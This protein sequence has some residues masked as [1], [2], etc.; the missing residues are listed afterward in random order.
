MSLTIARLTHFPLF[1]FRVMR[2]GSLHINSIN[3]ILQCRPSFRNL[4]AA[5]ISEKV[6]E[7]DD[8]DDD[9]DDDQDNDDKNLHQV[10]LKRKESEK[11]AAIRLLL[12]CSSTRRGRR[13]VHF[14]GTPNN[15]CENCE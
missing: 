12:I 6:E 8:D 14:R 1:I 13:M 4:K 3:E 10:A 15:R 9:D 5:G 2:D 11:A 7:D